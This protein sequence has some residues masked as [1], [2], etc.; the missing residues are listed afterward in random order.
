MLPKLIKQNDNGFA[1]K[2]RKKNNNAVSEHCIVYKHHGPNF[3]V[4]E[5]IH[6]NG[7]VK[8]NQN[9]IENGIQ[10]K[11]FSPPPPSLIGPKNKS[12]LNPNCFPQQD[13]IRGNAQ[14]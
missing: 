6:W 11:T 3:E 14:V 8:M 13:Y 4:H 9:T 1:F 10:N 12:K 2:K 7:R 5:T